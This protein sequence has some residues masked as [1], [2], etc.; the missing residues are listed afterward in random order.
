VYC[1]RSYTLLLHPPTLLLLLLL[2]LPTQ[3]YAMQAGPACSSLVQMLQQHGADAD[4][5]D[6][7]PLHLLACWS[8]AQVKAAADNPPSSSSS[9]AASTKS[10]RPTR[11]SKAAAAAA[12]DVPVDGSNSSAAAAANVQIQLQE[13]LAAA[14]MLIDGYRLPD[15]S[16]I[17]SCCEVDTETSYAGET[18]LTV[19]AGTGAVELAKLLLQNGAAVNLP[20]T[21]D[22]A[23]PIDIAVEAE[24]LEVACLLLEHGAEVGLLGLCFWGADVTMP[25]KMNTARRMGSAVI[26]L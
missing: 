22:A 25:R 9:G 13:Q 23:R 7:T 3:D 20:R 1:P 21:I 11:S 12:G 26:G 19:A 8:P 18:A 24:Q 10:S 17:G 15:G 14:R 4:V 6:I 5:D 16:L 2:L